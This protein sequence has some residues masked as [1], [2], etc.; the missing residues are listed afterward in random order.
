[1]A[2]NCK[3]KIAIEDKF[4]TEEECGV[5]GKL[6]VYVRRLLIALLILIVGMVAAPFI[7][8]FISINTLLGNKG[9]FILPKFMTNK[10]HRG[11]E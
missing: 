5:F 10:L 6:S 2:C 9:A 1:M 3:N 11:G 8:L 4:G 7:V